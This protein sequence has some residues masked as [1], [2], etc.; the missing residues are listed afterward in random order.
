MCQR[1]GSVG[2]GSRHQCLPIEGVATGILTVIHNAQVTGLCT[3]VAEHILVVIL[4][5]GKRLSA[6]VQYDG[7]TR[8][9]G[10]IDIDGVGDARP[11]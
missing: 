2:I 5:S 6:T 9:V 8:V 4:L 3:D 1:H 10:I 7:I 11:E